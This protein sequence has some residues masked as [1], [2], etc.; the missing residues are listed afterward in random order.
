MI[1]IVYFLACLVQCL[2]LLLVRTMT[3]LSSQDLYHTAKCALRVI[4][5]PLADGWFTVCY[6]GIGV[7]NS[8]WGVGWYRR[9][10]NNAARRYSQCNTY[11]NTVSDS[12]CS[13][14]QSYSE[15]PEN[16]SHIVTKPKLVPRG[17]TSPGTSQR[18]NRGAA[19]SRRW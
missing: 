6:K 15:Q 17:M 9:N 12:R 14:V 1:Y 2:V 10:V 19:L 3:S 7:Y 5:L 8:T 4:L 13:R 16:C 11:Y 18:K